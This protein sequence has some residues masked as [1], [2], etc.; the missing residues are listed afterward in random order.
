VLSYSRPRGRLFGVE[1]APDGDP[2]QSCGASLPLARKEFRKEFLV[3]AETSLPETIDEAYGR[4]PS[5][6]IRT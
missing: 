5:G 1:R 6:T 4:L 3:L 2:D